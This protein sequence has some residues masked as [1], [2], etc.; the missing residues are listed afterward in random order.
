[1]R[2]GNGINEPHGVSPLFSC[3]YPIA[4]FAA[5]TAKYN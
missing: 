4:A 2:W 3:V 1:L 5:F